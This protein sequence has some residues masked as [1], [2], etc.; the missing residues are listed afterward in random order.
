MH[1]NP[2]RALSFAFRSAAG[3]TSTSANIPQ[4]QNPKLNLKHTAASRP[5]PAAESEQHSRAH[6]YDKIVSNF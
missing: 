6:S 4:T 3:T 1:P 5:N 2:F